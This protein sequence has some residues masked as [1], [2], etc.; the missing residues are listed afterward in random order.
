M[1]ERGCCKEKKKT[2]YFHNMRF[3]FTQDKSI[4]KYSYVLKGTIYGKIWYKN[5]CY[6]IRFVGVLA[7]EITKFYT[8]SKE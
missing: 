1:V 4:H 3:F 7:G 5:K 8:N 2:P 6:D